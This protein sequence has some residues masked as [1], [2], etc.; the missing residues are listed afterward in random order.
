MSFGVV[1]H[2]RSHI[3]SCLNQLSQMASLP[4]LLKLDCSSGTAVHTVPDRATALK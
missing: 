3:N 4:A 2:Q 1:S